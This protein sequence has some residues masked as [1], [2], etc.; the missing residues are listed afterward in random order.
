MFLCDLRFFWLIID[1]FALKY[2]MMT[3]QPF[4]SIT[5][6]FRIVSY[7]FGQGKARKKILFYLCYLLYLSQIIS[8]L[9]IDRD[10]SKFCGLLVSRK[11]HLYFI[12]VS[13][14]FLGTSLPPT[15]NWSRF[16]LVIDVYSILFYCISSYTLYFIYCI[17]TCCKVMHAVLLLL[18]CTA[19]KIPYIYSFPGNSATSA[20]I[21]TFMCV[22]LT[23]ACSTCQREKV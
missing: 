5:A 18:L 15:P 14:A 8:F 6:R 3:L 2:L 11:K 1:P 17:F 7:R 16:D 10:P 23:S 21:S 12:S 20:P 9:C 4:F 13:G 22:P 19:T